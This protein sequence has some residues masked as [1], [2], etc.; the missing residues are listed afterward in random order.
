MG[1]AA[2]YSG[3]PLLR[4]GFGDGPG[5]GLLYRVLRDGVEMGWIL[6][7]ELEWRVPEPGVYRVEVYRYSARL[8]RTFFRLRPWIF[9]NP[10]TLRSPSSRGARAETARPAV[11]GPSGPESVEAL[12][13]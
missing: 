3:S 6:G 5:G 1:G 13:S 7:P 12:D 4:A 2:A 8:G 9:G 11:L 10:V